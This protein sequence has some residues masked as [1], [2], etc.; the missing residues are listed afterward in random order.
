MSNQVEEMHA[1]CVRALRRYITEANKTCRLLEDI[2]KFPINLETRSEILEQRL[3][4]NEAQERYQRA[5]Q[6]LFQ[7]ANWERVTNISSP[8]QPR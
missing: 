8:D 5:R 4:E 6:A 2:T 7:A 3:V 1:D